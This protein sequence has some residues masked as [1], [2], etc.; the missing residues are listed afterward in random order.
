V[1]KL[2]RCILGPEH[3]QTFMDNMRNLTVGMTAFETRQHDKDRVQKVSYR[4]VEYEIGSASLTMD[5]VIDESWVEDFITK[6]AEA[7]RLD[8]FRVRRLYVIPVEQSYHIRNG[9]MDI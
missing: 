1:V 2:I 4:G 8:Q 3:L 5:I 9:F 6:V 7:E